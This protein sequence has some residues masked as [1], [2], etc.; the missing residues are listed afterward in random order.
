MV[1]IPAQPA[2]RCRPYWASIR[3]AKSLIVF[4]IAVIT[5]A[6]YS[7]YRFPGK[8]QPSD[9][10]QTNIKEFIQGAELHDIT[11]TE[12]KGLQSLGKE[13]GAN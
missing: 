6:A 11:P 3:S 8:T 13:N 5:A 2:S 1:A 7:Y 10:G 4:I 12:P 9:Q